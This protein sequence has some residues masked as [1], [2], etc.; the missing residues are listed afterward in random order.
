MH[1]N[2]IELGTSPPFSVRP[3]S[4]ILIGV[5]F[6]QLLMHRLRDF[7]SPE[8]KLPGVMMV[9][10]KSRVRHICSLLLP[11]G[12]GSHGIRAQVRANSQW[13]CTGMFTPSLKC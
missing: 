7:E 2:S 11:V 4:K 9:T 13:I 12:Y 3:Y 1:Y 6:Y 8:L 5:L 10:F